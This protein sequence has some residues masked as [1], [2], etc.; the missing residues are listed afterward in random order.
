M[1]RVGIVNDLALAIEALRLAVNG[2]PHYSVAWV[3]RSGAEALER[4]AQDPPDMILM[5]L[6]M[7]GMNGVECT[8]DIIRIKPIPILVVTA[9]RTGNIDLVFQAMSAGAYDA[10]DTPKLL[11]G[12][13]LSGLDTFTHKL[14]RVE[15]VLSLSIK[16]PEPVV[17]RATAPASASVPLV[18]IGAST[19][20]PK[21][22][23]EVLKPFLQRR[24]V[25]VLIVQ[26]VDAYFTDGLAE[27]LSRESRFKVKTAVDGDVPTAGMALIAGSNDH[28]VMT[29]RGQLRYTREP[30]DLPYRPSVDVLFRSVAAMWPETGSATLLTGMGQDGARGLLA[31]REAGWR[32]IAQD[33]A[34]SV[35]YGMPR[36]AAEMKAAGKVLPLGDIGRALLR[37]LATGGG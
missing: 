23:C 5:D 6:I 20:G 32:T 31:L 26:H 8:R 37:D 36:A 22:I 30:V 3:A 24:D 7:P 21:A 11:P 2:V 13:Q 16:A 28:L 10:V 29:S 25:G 17:R 19:G 33:E 14:R 18:L 35:I 9:T 27:W 1:I 12:G 4:V 34:T 15:S